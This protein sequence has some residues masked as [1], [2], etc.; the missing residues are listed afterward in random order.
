MQP[1]TRE[2]ITRPWLRVGDT[3]I[4]QSKNTI[5]Y[6]TRRGGKASV[7]AG[8]VTLSGFGV[9][10]N[11]TGYEIDGLGFGFNSND[12][13]MGTS[14]N[15]DFFDQQMSLKG[16][17]ASGGE[18]GNSMGT[19]SESEGRK[20]DVTG[21]L[22]TTDFFNQLFIT[23]FEF[24]TANYD[25]DTGDGEDEVYDKAYRIR[26]GGLTEVT[27]YDLSY[28]YNGPQYEVV[29]NQ[30]IVRD[31]AG[32]DFNGGITYPLHA[33]RLLLNYSW[34]NV[35]DDDLF[36]RIYSFTSG[37]EYQYS[38]W[39]R[40][41]VSLLFQHNT[42]R[43]EDEPIDTESTS[44]DTSTLAGSIS[45]IEGPWAVQFS[46]SYSEQDDKTLNDYDTRL[47]SFAVVPSY[48][49]TYFSI[50]PSWSLNSSKDLV[51][52]VRTD[53]NTLTLD[54]YSGFL[55]DTVT[56]EVGGTYDWSQSDDDRVDMNNAALYGRLNY[57]FERLWR[58]E[59]STIA[60]EYNYNRQE[61]KI[62]DSTF[63]ESTLTLV[64]SSA[65]PYSF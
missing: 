19:W 59:D 51:T 65:I 23:E 49:H 28:S 29:G 27:D 35:E 9:L 38:G 4:E 42:Q 26:I 21:V 57:R 10:G 11:E 48:T 56:C 34:D 54:L 30:S 3:T 63:S 22:L 60:L 16:I 33:L 25:N 18:E 2:K 40:F 44:L 50:L 58:L 45:Y 36:A 20:G 61:D 52:E 13:I 64:I 47:F 62:Y 5:D 15:V 12:H 32:F 37:L 7:S 46:S 6:L 43:S 24:D 17:Y 14:I 1:T 8:D 31:W 39:Q 53:T 55:K 41:P